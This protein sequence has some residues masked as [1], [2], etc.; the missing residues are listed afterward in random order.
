MSHSKNGQF[1]F[2]GFFRVVSVSTKKGEEN[3]SLV[4]FLWC[5]KWFKRDEDQ[6]VEKKRL[7]I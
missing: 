6:E 5:G 7:K 4:Y 3:I 1:P 2:V